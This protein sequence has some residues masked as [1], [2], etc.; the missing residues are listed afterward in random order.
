M[1]E[2]ELMGQLPTIT[3]L[4]DKQILSI[5]MRSSE[6]KKWLDDVASLV[7]ERALSGK[8]LPDT[9]LVAGR[10]SRKW[11]QTMDESDLVKTLENELGDDFDV[12]VLYETKI[13]TP[14]AVEKDVGA[15]VYKKIAHLVEESQGKPTVVHVSDKRPALETSKRAKELFKDTADWD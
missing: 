13:R 3:D 10:G 12:D 5:W 14:A 6:I 15:K 7:E 2:S 11:A 9:K 4:N 1:S 8:P